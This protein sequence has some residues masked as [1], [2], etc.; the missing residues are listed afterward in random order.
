LF[1]ITQADFMQRL[2]GTTRL[3]G[4]QWGLALLAAAA[5]LLG[6][7]TGKRIARRTSP[8]QPAAKP[9]RRTEPG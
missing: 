4:G 1:L 9:A 2:L 5:L 7:E 3:S 6:C 8:A